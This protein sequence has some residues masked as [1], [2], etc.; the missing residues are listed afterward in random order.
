MAMNIDAMLNMLNDINLSTLNDPGMFQELELFAKEL[1]NSSNPAHRFAALKINNRLQENP[2][3]QNYLKTELIKNEEIRTAT[4]KRFENAF[5]TH[6]ENA[7]T[8]NIQS[9][10][11]EERKEREDFEKSI[12]LQNLSLKDQ[13]IKIEYVMKEMYANMTGEQQVEFLNNVN[14]QIDKLKNEGNET[15]AQDLAANVFYGNKAEAEQIRADINSGDPKR[16]ESAKRQINQNAIELF[17]KTEKEASNKAKETIDEMREPERSEA[18]KGYILTELMANKY[19]VSYKTVEERDKHFKTLSK[20]DQERLIKKAVEEKQRYDE[21]QEKAKNFLGENHEYFML[22][23]EKL[24]DSQFIRNQGEKLEEMFDSVLDKKSPYLNML[25]IRDKVNSDSGY[26]MTNFITLVGDMGVH[27]APKTPEEIEEN[28]EKIKAIIDL[29]GVDLI[30][31]LTMNSKGGYN[32]DLQEFFNVQVVQMITGNDPRLLRSDPVFKQ[33]FDL[34]K[35]IDPDNLILKNVLQGLWW[36]ENDADRVIEL[37]KKEYENKT[38]EEINAMIQKDREELAQI[39]SEK[40]EQI[41]D[42]KRLLDA[43]GKY[44]YAVLE[45]GGKGSYLDIMDIVREKGLD[46]MIEFVKSHPK[47]N[48]EELNKMYYDRGISPEEAKEVEKGLTDDN[49]NFYENLSNPKSH[50]DKVTNDQNLLSTVKNHPNQA[51]FFEPDESK[52]EK[53]IQEQQI[54]Q[55]ANVAIIQSSIKS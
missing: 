48:E 54:E 14:E 9:R 51:E 29:K 38:E 37:L 17:N 39:P 1:M 22:R 49:D 52:R 12:S 5:H 7:A 26:L 27:R 23:Q 15:A 36:S 3:Y 16:E 30:R 34:N 35:T 19:G 45:P 50:I 20:E 47:Y 13:L 8:A 18:L 40:Y 53:Q 46:K 10:R 6:R 55:Q 41:R 43:Y 28:N 33:I 24:F 44:Y 11:Q 31:T 4:D 21:K 2:Y 32:G 42:E 25:S